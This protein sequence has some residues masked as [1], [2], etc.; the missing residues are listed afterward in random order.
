MKVGGTYIHSIT[1]GRLFTGVTL[2]KGPEKRVSESV[3]TEVT[4]G[5]VFNLE[6]GEV[7]CLIFISTRSHNKPQ[8]KKTYGSWQ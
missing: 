7:G 1:T 3:F 8:A 4:K 5:L 6:C 2:G